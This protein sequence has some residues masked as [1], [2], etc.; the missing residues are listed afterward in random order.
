MKSKQR[1]EQEY[2][3]SVDTYTNA[4]RAWQ[5]VKR[6]TKKDGSDFSSMSRNFKNATV[7]RE[8][9]WSKNLTLRV[10]YQYNHG[11]TYDTITIGENDTVNDVFRQI[12]NRIDVYR[13]SLEKVHKKQYNVGTVLKE[14]DTNMKQLFHFCEE[15]GFSPYEI[16]DYIHNNYLEIARN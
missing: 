2:R 4:I 16:S 7:E 11:Y 1:I 15:K 12:E 13:K 14:V 3:D 10:N 9:D 6:V 8:Y 5:N